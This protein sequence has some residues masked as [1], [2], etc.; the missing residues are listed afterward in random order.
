[1]TQS[2]QTPNPD[3]LPADAELLHSIVDQTAMG[4]VVTA[5]DT[6]RF[7]RVNHAMSS[8]TGYSEQELLQ[9]TF[10]DITHADDVEPGDDFLRRLLSREIDAHTH[11][12][13]YLRKDGSQ[14][15]VR[16]VVTVIRNA[17]GSPLWYASLIHDITATMRAQEALQTSEERFR[18]M[19]EMGSDWYW[20]QDE[21]F[22]FLGLP[23]F[24]KKKNFNHENAIG[25]KRW[26][27]PHLGSLPD[28]V[29]QQHR[30]KLERHEPF[31]GFT[32][33]R[34]NDAG[35]LRYLSVSGEPVFDQKGAFKGY[36]GIG[37]DVTDQVEK[38][39]RSRR[40]KRA[41]ACSSTSTRSRCGSSTRRLSDSS[42]STTPQCGSMA[43][44]RKNFSA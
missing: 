7:L 35:E 26:E 33:M 37:K 19:V 32:Y 18:R 4:I 39:K 29:W 31:A 25:K 3:R 12:K 1:M 34:Y 22:R 21:Q 15:W 28:M 24:E 13:R 8:I 36:H 41:I 9:K 30:A 43:T 14:I 44:P 17:A 23:G 42:P 20:E 5:V 11:D 16:I 38:K 27:L 6:G 2:Q 10:R 40:A